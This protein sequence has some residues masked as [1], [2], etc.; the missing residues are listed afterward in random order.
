M[1]LQT[2]IIGLSISALCVYAFVLITRSRK[3]KEKK[4]INQLKAMAQEKA[5]Q[6]S[7]YELGFDFG[8][9]IDNIN[10][11]M[12][13]TKENK[14]NFDSQVIDLKT[15]KKCEVVILKKRVGKEDYFDRITLV[16]HPQV[17]GMSKENVVLFDSDATALPNG[18]PLMAK[19]WAEKINVML[20]DVKPQPAFRIAV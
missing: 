16:F 7:E 15:M 10:Q 8:L 4:L 11:H 17:P 14:T 3:N 20:K 1:D 9:G 13:Y 6:I 2:T 12:F 5:C 19:R 18:E